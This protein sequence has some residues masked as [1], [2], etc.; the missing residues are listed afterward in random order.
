MYKKIKFFEEKNEE[1]ENEKKKE[2]VCEWM[3]IDL[4]PQ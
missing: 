3:D 1:E 2:V 4:N